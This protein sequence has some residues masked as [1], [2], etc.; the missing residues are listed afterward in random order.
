VFW[1]DGLLVTYQVPDIEAAPSEIDSQTL[2]EP[3]I[4]RPHDGPDSR[5]PAG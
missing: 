2:V 1:V 5:P 4:K 3:A